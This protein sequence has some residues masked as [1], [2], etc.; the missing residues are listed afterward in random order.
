[1]KPNPDSVEL[2]ID[3]LVLNAASPHTIRAYKSDLRGLLDYCF[4]KTDFDTSN[5]EIYTATYLNFNKPGWSVNTINRKIAAFKAY[6]KWLGYVNF[7][8]DYSRPKTPPGI[9]HPIPEGV[10]GILKMIDVANKTS[11]QALVAMTGLMGLRIGEALQIEA[12]NV[13]T[14]NSTLT[15]FGKGNKTRVI[16]ISDMAFGILVRRYC[17]CAGTTTKLVPLTDRAARR[18]ITRL[19]EKAELSRSVA[20]HDMRM[21]FGTV[22]YHKS[23]GD[24]RAVQE[25]LGHS[26]SHTT[27][28]Y[29]LVN[30]EQMRKAAEIV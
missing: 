11:H 3:H 13:R 10:A 19:A 27:E 21:T 5:F 15:V 4:T 8:K 16:P 1:M 23:G 6:A 12:S 14:E 9:A 25:L 18:V 2:F 29:T 28:N 7:L 26:S 24:L 20:S 17:E 30:L 22:A